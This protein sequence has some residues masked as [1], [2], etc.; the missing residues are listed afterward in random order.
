MSLHPVHNS[1]LLLRWADHHE[2]CLVP[3]DDKAVILVAATVV[4]HRC[5]HNSSD[6]DVNIVAAQFLHVSHSFISLDE[7]LGKGRHVNESYAFPANQILILISCRQNSYYKYQQLDA[8][9]NQMPLFNHD[10]FPPAFCKAGVAFGG[11]LGNNCMSNSRNLYQMINDLY[12]R[13]AIQIFTMPT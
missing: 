2:T 3:S 10:N 9:S 12:I 6:R 1:G 8:L 7:K 5:S 4:E 13:Y 11:Q